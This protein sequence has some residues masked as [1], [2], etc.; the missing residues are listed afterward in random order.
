MFFLQRIP[1]SIAC[2]RDV[3]YSFAVFGSGEQ[4]K[5]KIKGNW[6]DGQ[7]SRYQNSEYVKLGCTT[8]TK[9]DNVRVLECPFSKCLIENNSNCVYHANNKAMPINSTVRVKKL[10]TFMATNEYTG[11]QWALRSTEHTENQ[12]L[13]SQSKCGTDLTLSEYKNFGFLRA[14]GHRIQIRKLFSMIET[15]ALSFE[16]E[17]VLLLVM[18]TLWVR[19]KACS[20]YK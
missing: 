7:L 9:P 14:D 13:S 19:S 17:D 11:L 6:N 8:K 15:E 20:L 18:Q 5:I 10:C 1:E 3:L 2:L 16:K 4:H 12:V